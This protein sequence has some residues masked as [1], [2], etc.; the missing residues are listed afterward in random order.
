MDTLTD[1]VNGV[2]DRRLWLL[3]A[4]CVVTA[5][6][7]QTVETAVE[8]AWPHQGRAAYLPPRARA[9]RGVWGSVAL[10]LLPGLLLAILNLAVLLWRQREE[11]EAQ[12]IGSLLVGLGWLAFVLASTD[13][14]P[15]GRYLRGLGTVG[16][17]ALA[18]LLLVG[19]ALLL[20]AFLDVIP[21]W[22]TVQDAVRD[23]VPF[24]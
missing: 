1:F 2:E 13:R 5:L 20:I 8:G 6:T 3:I 19:D 22:D 21:S 23:A 4:L 12:I 9:A 18:A 14:L 17:V 11:T 24:L 7:L 15:V 10:L 16:P